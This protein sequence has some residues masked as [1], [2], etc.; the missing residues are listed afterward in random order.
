[1]AITFKDPKDLY[2]VFKYVLATDTYTLLKST[3]VNSY[4]FFPTSAVVGDCLMFSAQNTR[5]YGKY[6]GI[7]FDIATPITATGLTVVWEYCYFDRSVNYNYG[8]SW[9]PLPNVKDQTNAFQNTGVKRVTWEIPDGW[10]NY[11]N[12]TAG[13]NGFSSAVYY[14]WFVRA[15]ITSV[16]SITNGGLHSTTN[17]KAIGLT[18]S[19]NAET[20]LTLDDLYNA[21]KAG[22]VDLDTRTGITTTDASPITTEDYLRP[23]DYKVLGGARNDLYLTIANYTGFTN[24]TVRLIGTDIADVAQTEDIVITGNGTN[25]ATKYFKTLNQTQVTAVTGTG[26]FDYTLTM[27]QWGVVHKMANSSYGFECNLYTSGTTNLITKQETVVFFKNWLPNIR[28]PITIGEVYTGDKVQKGTDFIFE[29][30]D[31]DMSGCFIGYNQGKF[32]NTHIRC[33]HLPTGTADHFHGFWGGSIG[34][35]SNQGVIDAYLE[36]F[37]Q[38]SFSGDNNSV[39]G[40]K[41]QGAHNETPG[42]IDDGIVNFG[43]NFAQRPNS[44]NKGD[45]THNND[46]SA[47]ITSPINPWNTDDIDGFVF[48][49]VDANWGVFADRNKVRW[50]LHNLTYQNTKMFETYSMLLKVIKEDGTALSG[51]TVTLT[52]TNGTQIFSYTTT[53]EGYI[54]QETGT[55][56][57]AT[58]NTITDT[59][60]AWTTSQWWFKEI[61]ITSGT[62]AGQRRIIMKG[63][64]SNTLT[65]HADWQVTPDATSTYIII[66][67]VRVKEYSPEAWAVN[68]YEWSAVIDYNP[69]K[70]SIVKQGFQTEETTMTIDRKLDSITTILK[71][72]DMGDEFELPIED[73]GD[74]FT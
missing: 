15:R 68:N 7:E 72:L 54:G 50:K 23:A 22:T 48:D 61:Y 34:S 39:I 56:T 37:R 62:G 21:D 38:S 74:L 70:L 25:Y 63:N 11:L 31:W 66:P 42:A 24:A 28:S 40:A 53:A 57:S 36:G 19:S 35:D 60:K 52:D 69:Y 65:V 6:Q 58:T 20:A 10:E 64:T 59:S 51:A 45:Y 1:M 18:I 8:A 14:N 26:S 16:S 17:S 49:Q 3:N 33:K 43:G 9:A 30:K 32:Y 71:G 41:V 4:Q 27:G 2:S 5:S 73:T 55:A 13:H 29:G 46:F 47:A 12:A 44:T 67:Y